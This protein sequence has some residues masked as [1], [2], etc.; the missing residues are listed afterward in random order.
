MTE[1]PLE[2]KDWLSKNIFKYPN[3]I[4]FS[5]HYHKRIKASKVIENTQVIRIYV[6]KKIPESLLPKHH[7]I[8]KRINDIET[9]VIEIGEVKAQQDRTIVY[10]PLVMG[11]SVGHYNITAGTLSI[12]FKDGKGN[13]YLSS[14]AHVLT[15]DPS[16]SNF[17]EKRILQPGPYDISAHGWDVNDP[18]FVAGQYFWHKQ[19]IPL[20]GSSNCPV[21]K[22]WGGIYNVFARALKRKTRLVA[23]LEAANTIDFALMTPSV[24]YEVKFLQL[25]ITN[26]KFVGLLFAGSD[27][28]TIIC[29][30]ENIIKE[31][32]YPVVDYTLNLSVGMNLWKEGRTTGLTQGQITDVSAVVTVD[33]ETFLA[34]FDDVIVATAM[35]QPGDSGSSVVTE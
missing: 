25:D 33:Y 26:K 2:L 6:K 34:Q 29:K 14:N 24:P 20:G 3:V 32:Y 23:T 4:G 21:A 12:P 10:R 17:S 18:K 31:G 15:P 35:S 19:I 8:P 5:N 7:V 16:L 13:I 28:S 27:T 11:I 9:D 30:V 1:I 22:F